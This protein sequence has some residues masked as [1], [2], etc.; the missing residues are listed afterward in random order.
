MIRIGLTGGIGAGKST[1]ARTFVDRGAY[2]IDSDVIAREVVAPGT[3]GLAALIE[4]FGT[5]IVA[6]DGSLDRPAL[7]ARAFVDDEQR[8]VLNAI[9]HPLVGARTWELLTAAPADAVVV[10][11]IPLLVE[12]G[13]APMFNLVVIVYADT[14]TRIARL[15]EH[16]GMAP[17]DARARIAAQATDEQRR[18]VA[19]VWLDNSGDPAALAEAAAVVWD[20]RLIP[21][22]A[23]V[24]AQRIAPSRYE[25]VESDPSWPDQARRLAARLRLVAGAEAI[26]VDHVGSTAV[27]GLAAKDVIDLQVTVARPDDLDAVSARL[28][29][30]GFPATGYTS[31]EPHGDVVDPAAW[32]KRGHGSADPGR[33][34]NVHVRV[35]GAANQTFALQFRDFLIAEAQVRSEYEA[36]K[37]AAARTGER[38]A[39]LA[40]KE[41]WF[42]ATYPRV[43]EWA[44][45]T[46]WSAPAT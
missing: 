37:R 13:L 8:A 45:L 43:R 12:N 42:A 14:E 5:D 20:E 21:F 46:G 38:E 3:E 44:A 33:P 2:L 41:P 10:Q 30:A 27:P 9:T 4:A 18:A 1:V 40:V 25:I 7:A 15:A 35:D 36:V 23:N 34:A 29:E 24:T 28:V 26:G 17:A 16:R 19:D 39:Y 11:D 31:D 22:A 6:E 32:I